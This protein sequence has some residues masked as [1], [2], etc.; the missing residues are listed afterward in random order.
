MIKRF[1]GA[2]LFAITL[3]F[4]ASVNAAEG[5]GDV[6]FSYEQGVNAKYHCSNLFNKSGITIYEIYNKGYKVVSQTQT[7]HSLLIVI[8]KQK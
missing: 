5:D 4:S 3:G 7:K 6:C 1:I 8:E 2:S